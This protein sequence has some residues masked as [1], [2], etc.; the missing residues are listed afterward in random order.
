M[1]LLGSAAFFSLQLAGHDW[2][3]ATAL[4]VVSCLHSG[5]DMPYAAGPIL[6]PNLSKLTSWCVN[7]YR[8][9]PLC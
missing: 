6:V 1:C 8:V 5:F 3:P 4:Q 9:L 2:I 7:A